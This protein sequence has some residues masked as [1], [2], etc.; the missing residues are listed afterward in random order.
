M[1]ARRISAGDVTVSTSG[2]NFAVVFHCGDSNLSVQVTGW[3]QAMDMT[4]E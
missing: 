2:V 4:V 3:L 1:N